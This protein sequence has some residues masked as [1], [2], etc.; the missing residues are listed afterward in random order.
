MQ[1]KINTAYELI[2]EHGKLR[3]D[4]LYAMVTD[5]L[6][7]PK[8]AADE[9]ISNFYT[10]IMLDGRFITL[11]DN[12]WA[13][14]ENNEFAKVHI[15]MNDIYSSDDDVIESDEGVIAKEDVEVELL[16]EDEE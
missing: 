9:D 7:L 3:F 15:D 4:Q 1:S 5:K 12:I 16:A 14:R 8:E 11:G 13:L 6:H 10:D 2:E